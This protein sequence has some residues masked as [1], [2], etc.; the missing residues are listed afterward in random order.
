MV[1]AGERTCANG[2]YVY[3]TVNAG[4]DVD[5]LHPDT[6]YTVVCGKDGNYGSCMNMDFA[7][8]NQLNLH[9]FG[10]MAFKDAG[11]VGSRADGLSTRVQCN[12][13]TSCIGGTYLS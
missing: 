4:E 5:G 11:A 8:P 1:C 6:A 7:A 2:T 9:V 10:E 3:H 13:N 12:Y